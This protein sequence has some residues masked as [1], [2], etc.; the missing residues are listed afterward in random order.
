MTLAFPNPSRSFDKRRNAVSFTGY[1]GMF[2]VSFFVETDALA[3]ASTTADE[4]SEAAYLR[5]FDAARGAIL[6]VAHRAY[7]HGRRAAY[8]LTASDFRRWK[9]A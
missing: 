7:S 5:A 1:D 4:G 8:V 9:A 2:E 6:D 3:Q